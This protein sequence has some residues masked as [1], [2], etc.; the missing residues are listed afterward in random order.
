MHGTTHDYVRA[1]G[2][3]SEGTVGSS[4]VKPT[5]GVVRTRRIDL[6][7]D[8]ADYLTAALPHEMCHVVLADYF[9]EGPPPLWFDEGVAL[10]YDPP[11][12]QRLHERD[13]RVGMRRANVF[14]LSELLAL[15]KYPP[16][17]RCGAFYGQSVSLV[18]LLLTRG[19]PM[20]LL[21]CVE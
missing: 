7:T 13:L 8:V 3:G 14:P 5:V 1:V 17:D 21:A 19:S 6:R 4:L 11:S 15:E 12:K 18:R 16:A 2:P 20:Q 9:R 10:Q